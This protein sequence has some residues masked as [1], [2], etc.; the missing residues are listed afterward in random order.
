MQNFDDLFLAHPRAVGE[1]YAEHGMFALGIDARMALAAGAALV[2]AVIPGLC[3][4]TAS[5]IILDMHAG[6]VARRAQVASGAASNR[7]VPLS[8]NAFP[9]PAWF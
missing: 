9:D 6:I 2:H 8:N 5:Q 1:S 7:S 3:K 4:T